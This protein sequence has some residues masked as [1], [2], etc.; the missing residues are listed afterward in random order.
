MPDWL[1][2]VVPDWLAEVARPKKVP[3]PWGTMV[4]AVLA[5]WVPLAVAFA[6]GQR[7]LALLPAMG[8]LLSVTIDTG[9]PYWPRVERIGAAAV[10]GGAPGLLIGTVIHGRGW[11]AVLAVVVIA[12]V[13]AILARLGRLGSVTGLQLFI[14]SA[15]GLGPIGLL[16][17]WWQTALRVPRGGGV[18][19]AADHARVPALAPVG[20]AEGGRRGLLRA[21]AGPAADRHPRHGRSTVALA[22]R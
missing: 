22:A 21:R 9:G 2:G 19:A 11:V 12:G 16:R 8:G 17:P 15:L 6:T 3:V 1:I 20:G 13:S 10:L 14:Y 18:G 7:E 4:R 5:L